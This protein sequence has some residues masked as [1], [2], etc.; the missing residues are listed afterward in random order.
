M[1]EVWDPENNL[2]K[3]LF[4]I[5]PQV[6]F[7]FFWVNKFAQKALLV[8]KGLR[9]Q[10]VGKSALF[11]TNAAW[12][13]V[14]KWSASLVWASQTPPIYTLVSYLSPLLRLLSLSLPQTLSLNC[15]SLKNLYFFF[16]P[17]IW[18]K[19]YN[20]TGKKIL[21]KIKVREYFPFFL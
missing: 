10:V 16:C 14:L 21:Q 11:W 19:K 12:K 5:Q 13:T 1:Y 9:G 2:K 7:F 8:L 18:F 4:K 20:M 6:F 15:L 3:K 17:S